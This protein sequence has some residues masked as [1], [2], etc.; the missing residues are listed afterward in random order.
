MFI[1]L[2]AIGWTEFSCPV[3]YIPT[4]QNFVYIFILIF[5][6]LYWKNNLVDLPIT[7]YNLWQI[8]SYST[9]AILLL[10]ATPTGPANF[11]LN[12][13]W[14][15]GFVDGDGS[16]ILNI[17]QNSRLKTGWNVKLF[18][19]ISLHCKDKTL[20]EQIKNFF[21]VGSIIFNENKNVARLLVYSIQELEIIIQHFTKFIL[22]THKRAD[23]ELFKQAFWLM[24]NK[25]HLTKAG[26]EKFLA[27]RASQ[28]L[29]FSPKLIESFPNIVPVERPQVINQI[30]EDPNW[31]AGF[32]AAEG[33]FF[34]KIAK[35]TTVIGLRVQLCFQIT[36]HSKDEQLIKSLI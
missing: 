16:F 11:K 12:P 5:P 18:L 15:T 31:L 14:V 26:L 23:F 30:I 4:L 33:C 36:Q 9:S 21:G 32:T 3:G 19:Y 17:Y 20:L 22:I 2:L 28:N 10:S 35:A 34:V 1:I 6:K 7:Q 29:G 25:D 13:W 24:K 27:I 8:R